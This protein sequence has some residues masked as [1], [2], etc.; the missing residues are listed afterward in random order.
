M[1]AFRNLIAVILLADAGLSAQA[2]DRLS[3]LFLGDQGHHR[4]AVIHAAVAAEFAKDGIDLSYTANVAELTADR[5]SRFDCLLIYRDSGDL[6]PEA[7]AALL[8][9]IDRGNGLVAVHC[10]SHCF[11]NSTKYTA[12]VGGRFDHHETGEFRAK[13]IDAQHPALRGVT[14][15]E[16]WDETYVHNELSNDRQV[17]MVR[18]HL[19]GYEPYTWVRQQG[20]GRVY[21]S[22]LGHDE[23]TWRV[24]EYRR[25]LVAA[26]RWAAGR[27]K[28]DV[29]A[30]E[31]IDAGEG[32]PNYV[33][34]EKWG[35]EGDRLKRMPKPLSPADSQRHVHLPEGFRIE[36]FAAEPDIVKPI[37]MSFDERGRL[38]V[39]ESVDYPNTL[40]DD[41]QQ[42]GDDR[43]K[44]CEDS[45]GDGRADRF[46]VFADRL[47]LPTSVLP[48]RG[49]AIVAVAPHLLYL[50]DTDGDLRADKRTVLFTGFGRRDTHAVTSNLHYGLDNWV[51]AAVGYSG[52]AVRVHDVE[53]NFKQG[54]YRF[55]PDGSDFE[56]LTS[57]SNNTW[58]LG[59]SAAGD[60]FASTA[61]NEH[62]IF[63]A[64]PNR[65][66][67][68]VRGWHGAGS[69][70]IEDHKHYHP[71]A[72]DVRQMDWHGAFT[73]ASG[74]ELYTARTF[75]PE[76]WN[77]A[78]LV[79]EPTGHLVHLDWLVPQG[80]SFVAHDGYNLLASTDP[81]SAPIAAQVGPDGA[82]WVLDWY[83]YVVQ[84]NPTPHG[85]Q[86]GP[87]NAYETTLRD[88]AHGRVYRVVYGQNAGAPAP[89]LDR[90]KSAALLAGLSHENLFWR[91]QAQR[92]L[93]ERGSGDVAT[94]LV[95][96]ATRDGN[97]DAA[98]HA[99]ATL[100]GLCRGE[101]AATTS[102][103]SSSQQGGS[104]RDGQAI[105]SK[106]SIVDHLAKACA[107]IL[108]VEPQR[109]SD[110]RRV[111]LR[112]L[113][114]SKDAVKSVL[115]FLKDQDA[116]VRLDALLALAEMPGDVHTASAMVELLSQPETAKDRWIPLAATSAAA[117]AAADFIFVAA[118]AGVP[119]PAPKPLVATIRTVAEHYA[120]SMP[121]SAVAE[122]L[123]A[124]ADADPS[125]ASAAVA[126]LAAGW[127]TDA[128]PEINKDLEAGFARLL[129][130]LPGSAGLPV[131][132]LANRWGAGDGLRAAAAEMRAALLAEVADAERSDDARLAALT[133]TLTLGIDEKGATQVAELITPK[134][135]P[136]FAVGVLEGLGRTNAPEVG[137]AIVKAWTRFTPDA[138]SKAAAV[139]LRRPEW[140]RAF[141]AA[142]NA[143]AVPL[144]SLSVEVE[145]RLANHADAELRQAAQNLLARG[146]RLADPDRQQVFD[147]LRPLA[148]KR[149]DAVA[150]KLVFEKNCAKCH[151][152]GGA[153]GNVGPDLTGMAAR[154]RVDILTDVLDPNRSVEGNFQ[155]YTV[156]TSDG[157]VLS[158]LMASETRTTI[159]L[160]DAEARKQV[161][162]RDE[163]DELTSSKQSIMPEGF[164]K[165]PSED[166]VNLLEFLAARGRYFPLPL[167]KAATAVS[168]IG[169]FYDHAATA[170]RL[171]FTDW[172]PRKL[173]GIP[174]HLIDPRGDR[175][176]NVIMLY[177]PNGT[178]PPQMPKV[179]SVPCNAPA[180]TLHL[181]SGVSGWG[182]P[183][184]QKGSLTMTV[185][186]VYTDGQAE[187]HPLRN[188][189][190]F[191]D[192]IR[193]V[194]VPGSKFAARLR[195]QQIRYLSIEPRRRVEIERVEFIKGD[196]ATAP[197]VMAAT[198]ETVE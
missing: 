8:A 86:T 132:T 185:R 171:I 106:S 188:G 196:D 41:P 80:S 16:S 3:V 131:I 94:E 168:T 53:H 17:L 19:N 4:P 40:R 107:D 136:E 194:D 85:F 166:L 129:R 42:N 184:G 123:N 198:V 120:R 26:I 152:H 193:Q 190:H 177:S 10:A 60:I 88:K 34:G 48:V 116:Q 133:G 32:L 186:L 83:N 89:H 119:E 110:L 173:C 165:L 64:I 187:D 30:T 33:S 44:I 139:L 68:S 5:L 101:N 77:R 73:A 98:L 100:A 18:E 38:W 112:F 150:G 180:K 130:R 47:N 153:G 22:A 71:I 115:A 79:C 147:R 1:T 113:P 72:E 99:V 29:P 138:Q 141:L 160:L 104:E 23:R 118:R 174:F 39:A 97:S 59:L 192:Y 13:I 57:T 9:Y 117:R 140:T 151:R 81:W 172:N 154:K 69:R 121:S 167:D 181:L 146:G 70:T 195:D 15:F 14:S 75:P 27:V 74:H 87:G 126:G 82:V 65:Y 45:D 197:V 102:V 50:E 96:L 191:A 108:S 67:E 12:L 179:V 43:I 76:Y 156:V 161:I 49:G 128:P 55:R 92:L 148:D 56:V 105:A 111:A 169:M 58:G 145:Q 157:R 46:T 31:Y 183:L 51:Y 109:G 158:G 144:A 24:P 28:D 95:Q 103:S 84:H 175:V 91:L 25:Q 176:R 163:I 78:A 178:Y 90:D 11:R 63:L 164:E 37:A 137:S 20:K 62:S 114:R 21:Y 6:P 122:M 7:E 149:G 189:E 142:L 52:G 93:V 182:Y 35:T 36:L 61:N 162:L 170:E 124:L 155:Q 159:E 127:P 66:F 2:D 54:V 135:S 125:I 134:A 143:N